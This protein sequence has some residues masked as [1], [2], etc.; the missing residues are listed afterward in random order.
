MDAVAAD[1]GSGGHRGL[2]DI[3]ERFHP[4]VQRLRVGIDRAP[5]ETPVEEYVLQ[6][7]DESQ[8]EVMEKTK[9]RAAEA[10]LYWFEAGTVAAANRYNAAVPPGDDSGASDRSEIE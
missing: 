7:F 1:R 5:A 6:R 3:V 2:Q 8:R 10:V 4:N 9:E